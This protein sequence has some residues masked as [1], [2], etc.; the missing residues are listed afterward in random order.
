MTNEEIVEIKKQLEEHEKRIE[1]LE[2]LF[3]SKGKRIITRRKSIT[4]HLNHLKSEDFF[5]Q[6]KTTQEIIDRLAYEGYH[7]RQQSMTEPLQR[8]V[9]QEIL[10]RVKK[11]KIWAYCKR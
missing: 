10:G 9:R 2:N 11:N 8:A 3:K 5:D 1:S 4:D 7:Y 6:P